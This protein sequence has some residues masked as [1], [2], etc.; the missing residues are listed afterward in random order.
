MKKRL[1]ALLVIV[2]LLMT[3]FSVGVSASE[4]KVLMD[5]NS[6]W[7]YLDN[8]TDPAGSG[9]RTAWTMPEFDDDTWKT[10]YGKTAKFGGKNGELV[11]LGNNATPTV[12]L[13]QR[14]NGSSENV[15]TYFFR[16]EFEVRDVSQG[17]ELKGTLKY[18]DAAIV[19]V[20]GK[21]VAAYHE[22][23]GGFDTNM[24]YGGAGQSSP[25]NAAF[26]V[27]ATEYLT[28]GT[29]T[30]AV[31]V[32]Q[33][34]SGSSDVYFEMSELKLYRYTP[35][36]RTVSLTVGADETERNVTW[37]SNIK[38]D[39]ILQYAEKPKTGKT[40]YQSVTAV[41][42]TA[43]NDAGFYIHRATLKNLKPNTEYVYRVVNGNTVSKT[44]DFKT[45]KK[46]NF[47][48]IFTGDPQIAGSSNVLGWLN[49]LETAK[50]HF[51]EAQML[52][53][54]G[55]QV[56]TADSEDQYGWYLLPYLMQSY[57]NAPVV[58]NHDTSSGAFSEH[59]TVPNAKL[60]NKAY[61]TTP[62]GSNY[63]YTYNDVLFIH[64]N[65]NNT[66]YASHISYMEQVL[67]QN[68]DSKW[69]IVA[70]HQ[71]MFSLENG[72]WTA[73]TT[74]A[75]RK[76]LVPEFDRLGIDLALMGHDHTY[77]R[78]HIM[79]G[80]TPVKSDSDYLTDPQGTLYVAGGSGSGSKYYNI[81]PAAPTDF[82]A[83]YWQGY[84]AAFTVVDVTDTALQLTTYKASDMSVIDRVSL[85]SAGGGWK[86]IADKWY[87]FKN[88]RPLK[89]QWQLDSNGWCYLG[90][91]GAMKT[92]AWVKDSHGWCYVGG[93]GYIVKSDWVKDGGKWYYL[94]KN[95]YMVSNTWQQ[96]ANGWCYL[97]SS[98]AMLTNAWVKDSV[99]WCYVGA[100]GYAVTN[101]WKQDRVGWC[102]LNSEG[103]MTKNDWVKDGGK[104]YYLDG[105][106]YMV[107]NVW[108]KDS[109]G[110]CYL[111]SSGAMLTN[112]WVKDSVGWCYVG[113][114]GYAVTDC[115]KKDSVGWCYL[116]SEGSM[117]KNDW[118]EDGGKWYYLDGNGYMVTGTKKIGGKTYTFNA[119][120]VW[121][122]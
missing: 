9:S 47:S 70:F 59:F 37:H 7:R 5:L 92:N 73:S 86:Q 76:A 107:A 12:P 72:R 25:I 90:A 33:A 14:K 117:T 4:E 2:C 110:W 38:G 68:P 106:G 34:S 54:A 96:D 15:P 83:K 13:Q 111:G 42:E 74:L 1:L 118:V 77:V 44:Y 52:L 8:G 115:W 108:K 69:Q 16:A 39:G 45:N 99:G 18:D 80:L 64:L 75:H 91:D 84:S 27:D 31:E 26:S 43:V 36:Q 112:A 100:D 3:G 79:D 82:A 24:S 116:N 103:S 50:E 17:Y 30:I 19:Y 97:G 20:N 23:D 53:T 87:Y 62:A 46:G 101:C 63:W 89:N 35:E 49:T 21:R 121:V 10:S 61:G 78:T 119:S 11:S 41:T 120:G 109:K 113:A 98:G 122:A 29:N 88:G 56:N 28:V 57:T 51:P 58:G 48:F 85:L 67:A 55:D 22:P 60:N 114:D 93:N 104:W 66:D 94:D 40:V 32:H 71:T 65:T 6:T 95:G 102:Y 81:D 105:N